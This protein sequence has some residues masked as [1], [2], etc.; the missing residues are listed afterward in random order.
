MSRLV[1]LAL[2]LG[3][4]FC[5]AA[6]SLAGQKL[7]W[8]EVSHL[9]VVHKLSAPDGEKHLLGVY[10]HEGV[11]L[12]PGGDKAAYENVG[13]FDVYESEDGTRTHQGYGKMVF[14]DG[15]TII[16]QASGEEYFVQ[17]QKL[18]KV[19][20]GGKFL[21]GTG[22]FKGISGALSFSGGYVSGL[23]KDDTGGD[24]VLD[25]IADYTLTK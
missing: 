25:Y 12:F 13:E 2:T 5:L 1:S 18:P 14:A 17:G 6:P 7:V 10:R 21:G 3:L 9:T 11:C 23:K 15:S 4:L 22:R 20:G 19:K 16:F 24:A 8:Q